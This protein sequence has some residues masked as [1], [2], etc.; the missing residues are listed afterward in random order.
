MKRAAIALLAIAA[1]NV[2]VA[3]ANQEL[4]TNVLRHACQDADMHGC[5]ECC[6]L[7]W[8]HDGR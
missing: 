5:D 2:G 7:P 6:L 8:F 3:E 1:F 4:S